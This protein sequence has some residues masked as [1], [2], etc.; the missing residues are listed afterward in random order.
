[1][2]NHRNVA[3]DIN[4]NAILG[5][6]V[7][8]KDAATGTALPTN[9]I[10]STNT[11][12][13]KT[14][15]FTASTTDG[16]FEFYA[17]NG[18]YTVSISATGYTG[19]DYDI[20]LEET[21][22]KSTKAEVAAL[23]FSQYDD[24]TKV[25]ITSDDGKDS[26]W[27][28]KYNATPETYSDNGGSEF[29][30]T[31]GDGTIGIV[32]DTFGSS[33]IGPDSGSYA[34]PYFF[35]NQ[36]TTFGAT[37]TG[38]NP[39]VHA[40]QHNLYVG[41][42]NYD[43]IAARVIS[44]GLIHAE[45]DTS[46]GDKI[47]ITAGV[48][49]TASSSGKLYGMSSSFTVGDGGDCPVAIGH[50]VN[51]NV[52]G[53]GILVDGIGFNALSVGD[54]SPSGEYAAYTIQ[55]DG[56]VG[57]DSWKTGFLLYTKGGTT[58]NPIAATGS[59]FD[60]DAGFT[61]ANIFNFTTITVTGNILSFP[62]VT[63][64]GAGKLTLADDIVLASGKGI[65]FSATSDAAG[66]TSE[67]LD[68]YE[69]GTWTPVITDLTNDATSTTAVGTYTKI[70][71]MVH[72]KGNIVLSSL[73]SVSGS[74]YLNGFPFAAASGANTD[75]V[76]SVGEATGLSVTAGHSICGR[77]FPAQ[78]YALLSLWDATT[79]TTNLQHTELTASTELTVEATY[80]V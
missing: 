36:A 31:G 72:I 3:Q 26:A 34:G 2:K 63:L 37:V 13:P 27:T 58:G 32:K 14:N 38:A 60:Y 41:G 22:T 55:T 44:A 62:N 73:G 46:T 74:V 49:S 11:G 80:Y 19:Q 1:M 51:C 50:E 65:D 29:I 61:L 30:P 59:L 52:E 33:Q 25:F 77:V 75:S 24:G 71:R 23:F 48:L 67:L 8:I 6:T 9:T 12:T 70:G 54:T 10:Y 47:G 35:N 15:P 16:E 53:T 45:N 20:L 40:W 56:D 66:M 43:A 21:I 28:V 5:A 18:R 17:A 42:T 76:L 69:E 57:T 78:S 64:T 39:A 79:G 7:T 4:G 68:D